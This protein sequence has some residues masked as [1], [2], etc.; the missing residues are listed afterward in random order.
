MAERKQQWV[1]TDKLLLVLEKDNKKARGIIKRYFLKGILPDWKALHDWN[2]NSTTRHLDLLLFLYL[3]PSR[4]DAVLRPLRD[5]FLNNP[6]ALPADRLM[7]FDHLWALGLTWASQGGQRMF[8]LSEL[9]KELGQPC[10]DLPALPAPYEDC[11]WVEVHTEG[12]NERLFNLMWPDLNQRRVSLP[13]TRD[14]YRHRAPRFPVDQ[15]EFDLPSESLATLWS[16][17]RWLVRPAT[18]SRGDSDMIF[19][20]ERPLELWYLH[21]STKD[22]P[23]ARADRELVLLALYRIFHFDREGE[24]EN[25]PR[26]RFVQRT[27]AL[28][29]QREFSASFRALVDLSRS[30]DLVVTDPWGQD[31]KVEAPAF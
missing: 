16:M 30:P 22:A 5:Q 25:S 2:Q 24:P 1:E 19:Q 17:S 15:E 28:L 6:H 29:T 11:R 10:G 8:R 31:A 26:N 7:G 3:H 18:S 23:K 13:V 21:C 27:R 9:E 4:D 20:Y 12:Q 14:T